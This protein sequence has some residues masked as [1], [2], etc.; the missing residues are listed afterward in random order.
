[1]VKTPSSVDLFQN[2]FSTWRNFPFG[3]H[4][5]TGCKYWY[6]ET[7]FMIY[8]NMGL[9][10]FNDSVF[11]F[12]ILLNKFQIRWRLI[13]KYRTVWKSCH[14]RPLHH[15]NSHIPAMN[16]TNCITGRTVTVAS[17]DVGYW[18]FV[19]HAHKFFKKCL[20][21]RLVVFSV[22]HIPPTP[23]PPRGPRKVSK[24]PQENDGNLGATVTF[25]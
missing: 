15:Q 22:A 14:Y 7:T 25:V 4:N 23:T 1:M 20:L 9:G 11:T 6:F 3:V 10:C 24:G 8:K 21:F 17:V 5:F 18:N 13:M 12:S 2:Y 19:W 16:N